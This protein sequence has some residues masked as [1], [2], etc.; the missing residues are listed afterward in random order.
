MKH[1]HSDNRVFITKTF[2]DHLDTC[3]QQQ[4]LCR[5]GA[6]WQNG[7]IERYIGVIT[8][9]A[10]TMLLHAMQMW[11]NVITS[12]F[13]SFAF[14]QAV[15]LHN[16]SLH[17]KAQSSPYTL[18]TNEDPPLSAND[19]QVFGSLV[20]VLDNSLQTGTLGPGKWKERAFQGIYISHSQH[21]ASN[22][23]MVYN[24][25]TKLVSPQ[26]HV[27]HDES[28]DT[29]Q[30]NMSAANTESKLEEMLDALFATSEWVH[31][32]A[33]LD[34]MELCTTHHYFNSSWDLAQEMIHA[35]C[36]RKCTCDLFATRGFTFQGSL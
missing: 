30:L 21:H 2:R 5:V 22:V 7:V 33:Y 27:A 26:Y 11:P 24:P 6:H 35:T 31:S 16:Y 14:L 1:I 29:M 3:N 4:S 9:H 20:Y 32:E 17:S 18:F 19:F 23:I 25:V 12:K 13:W 15:N 34:D 8:T 10:H 36:P 28:F